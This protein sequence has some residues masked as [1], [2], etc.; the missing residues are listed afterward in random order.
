MKKHLI[1][2]ILPS[3]FLLLVSCGKSEQGT[4]PV[5]LKIL[6]ERSVKEIKLTGNAASK[7][8]E[9]S[10]LSWW[11][12]SLVLLPQYV[13]STN[14]IASGK[15][16]LISRQR[17]YDY[18]NGIDTTAV[19]PQTVKVNTKGFDA[20]GRYGSGCEAIAFDKDTCYLSVEINDYKSTNAI[21]IK[22][23]FNGEE[24]VFNPE[25]EQEIKSQTGISNISEETLALTSQNVFTIHEAN[26]KN[27]NP[28]PRAHLLDKS[29][30]EVTTIPFPHIEYR[31]TDATYLD[32][33]NNF[34]VINY[35]YPGDA[36][37]LKPAED[38]LKVKFGVGKSHYGTERVERL[39][40]LHFSK[41]GISF[42]Q[43]APVYIKLNL[44]EDARNWE[45]L[46]RLDNKG[47]LIVTDTYPRTIL[48]FVSF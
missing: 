20:F 29:L 48:G 37:D 44:K 15:F 13:F 26:G 34:W 2:I 9:F 28:E 39:V 12:D 19:K 25:T 21:V 3:L 38:E 40:Q 11:R 10:G 45:G 43:K 14:N 23:Y 1:K 31:I 18:L 35:F 4:N 42:V 41:T 32:S 16:Y 27:V 7:R 30:R 6:K 24:F 36:R 47:F 46:A 33:L 8:N 5:K 17:I 22:G